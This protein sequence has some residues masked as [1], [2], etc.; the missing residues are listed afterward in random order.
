[1]LAG[2]QHLAAMLLDIVRRFGLDAL[3]ERVVHRDEVPILAAPRHHRRRRGVAG[4]PGVVDPLDGVRRAGLAGQIGARGGRCQKRHPRAAQQRIDGKADGGIGHVD[5]RIDAIDVEPFAHDRR[6]HV[7]LVLVIGV[8]DLDLDVLAAAIEILR[9]HPRR[10][11]RTHAVG[12]LEDAGDVI[13]HADPHHLIGDLRARRSEGGTRQ[14]QRQNPAQPL[15][16]RSPLLPDL[17]APAIAALPANPGQCTGFQHRW[18][19]FLYHATSVRPSRDTEAK[20]RRRA[21]PGW[22]GRER[23]HS[24][25]D[26]DSPM[27]TAPAGSHRIVI[28]GAGFGGLEAAHRLAGAPVEITLI[29]RRNHHLFQPLLY[30]VAT[31]SLATSEIAWPI[32]YLLRGRQEVTTLFATVSGVDPPEGACCSKTAARCPMTRWCSPPARATPISAMTNGSRSRRG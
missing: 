11:H 21:R 29:D 16:G 3:A 8:D 5:H 6:A 10:F 9:G 23:M 28:V 14:C 31:A 24:L 25:I 12:V 7:G 13:E 30:Q 20:A 18:L 17:L 32:R 26:G 4:R 1:M 27:T 15:H 22:P 19:A 2:T